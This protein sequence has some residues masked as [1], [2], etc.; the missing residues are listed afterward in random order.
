MPKGATGKLVTPGQNQKHYLAGALEPKTG[1]M[2]Y[3]LGIRKTNVL[4]RPLLAQL[5]EHYAKARVAK[6][7]VGVDTSG[8][9]KAKAV[10][11]WLVEHPRFE[12]LFL[13]TSCPQANPIERAFGA[14]HDKCTR[15]PQRK[16]L[17]ALVQEVERH[18]SPNGPWQYK[19]S[20]LYYSPDVT[21]AGE[22]IAKEPPLLQAA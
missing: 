7:Y 9:H 4:V 14:V 22:R 15:N 8:I 21:T 10:E 18:L 6:V 20:P 1:P 13:P 11:R 19:L 12:L 2:V 16:H 5:E 3:C 17:A